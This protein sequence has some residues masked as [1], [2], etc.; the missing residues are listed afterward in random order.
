[1]GGKPPILGKVSPQFL[2]YFFL[3]IEYKMTQDYKKPQTLDKRFKAEPSPDFPHFVLP[4]ISDL[5]FE[6]RDDVQRFKL[7][8][9]YMEDVYS[10]VG[11]IFSFHR[12]PLLDEFAYWKHT[13]RTSKPRKGRSNHWRAITLSPPVTDDPKVLIKYTERIA[14]A[15]STEKYLYVYEFRKDGTLHSHILIYYLGYPSDIVRICESFRKVCKGNKRCYFID[16]DPHVGAC[17]KKYFFKQDLSDLQK[18]D[19][20]GLEKFY[21]NYYDKEECLS[22]KDTDESDT[23][24]E[25]LPNQDGIKHPKL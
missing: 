17:E 12:L 19:A 2:F 6:V 23:E 21:S 9:A 20:L 11:E 3:F 25:D 1:M 13:Q 24:N 18:L 8:R 10:S 4:Q 14:L 7:W 15:A 16:P 22:E 5:P